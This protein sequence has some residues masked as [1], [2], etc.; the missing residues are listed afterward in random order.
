MISTA[1]ANNVLKDFY[2]METNLRTKLRGTSPTFDRIR[3]KSVG[4][5]RQFVQPAQIG[6]GQAVA[7]DFDT[8]YN[9]AVQN[10]LGPR[11]QDFKFPWDEYHSHWSFQVKAKR[12]MKSRGAG[13]FINGLRRV[14]DSARESAEKM[15]YQHMFGNGR[16]YLARVDGAANGVASTDFSGHSFYVKIKLRDLHTLPQFEVGTRFNVAATSFASTVNRKGSV[17]KVYEVVHV[18]G[19]SDSPY[20]FA[21]LIQPATGIVVADL[22]I[23][24]NAQLFR[25]GDFA[26]KGNYLQGFEG[27][28]PKTVTGTFG[29]QTRTAG[30]SAGGRIHE[31][32]GFYFDGSGT[33]AQ[34]ATDL[35][36]F[37][38]NY[39]RLLEAAAL[40]YQRGARPKYYVVNP[41]TFRK[42]ADA[43]DTGA[44]VESK[45]MADG[46]AVYSLHGAGGYVNLYVDAY[47]PVDVAYGLRHEDWCL[48]SLGNFLDPLK[49]DGS[50]YDRVNGKNMIEGAISSYATLVTRNPLNLVR[51]DLLKS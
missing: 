13:S 32:A 29:G 46:L 12:Q 5:G 35:K 21:V 26:Q 7:A 11:F 4:S 44:K 2:S 30:G 42:L 47:C 16:G 14:I 15:R 18:D 31:L 40:A 28:C 43:G 48:V 22:N 41:K 34:S 38:H 17:D 25:V 23:P 51:V 50:I 45:T 3:L 6:S 49:P 19:E 24:A 8:A 10:N 33:Y 20:V 39:Q 37:E 9:L 1:E 36:R 27:W